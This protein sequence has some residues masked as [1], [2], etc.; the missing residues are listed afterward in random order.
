MAATFSGDGTFV[1]TNGNDT[2]NLGQ[3]NDTA[4]GLLGKDTINAASRGPAGNDDDQYCD[5]EERSGDGGDTLHGGPDENAI[6][7][8]GGPNTM[9]G[10]GG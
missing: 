6:F 7:G 9:Y 3:G 8:G 10:G 2:F 4:Y 1:G 5:I